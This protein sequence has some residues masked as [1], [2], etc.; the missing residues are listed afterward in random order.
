MS[1]DIDEFGQEH[2]DDLFRVARD[3]AAYGGLS[4]DQKNALSAIRTW[5]NHGTG[6]KQT[7]TLAGYA[8]TGKSYCLSVLARELQGP[9][10][11]CA[12]TG[13]ASSVLA[14]KLS[15]AG[16]ATTSRAVKKDEEGMAAHEPRP[17][18]G[19]IHGL[20][21][22][23]CPVCMIAFEDDKADE[24][25]R[26]AGCMAARQEYP[27]VEIT[28]AACVA[29]PPPPPKA[30]GSCTTCNNYRFLRRDKLDRAY[31]L[32]VCDE[33]SMVSDDLLESLLRHGVPLLAVGD[34][35]QLPPV[36]GAGSLMRY[37]DVRLEKIHRQAKGNPIIR[38]SEQIRHTGDIADELEDGKHFVIEPMRRLGDWIKKRYTPKKLGTQ[39]IMDTV[40]ISW[41][42]RLR[43]SLNRDVRDALNKTDEI[44]GLGEIVVCLKNNP[45]VYNGM[46][47]ILTTEGRETGSS[48]T[49]KIAADLW[50][51][52]D[53][54]RMPGVAMSALQF[55]EEKTI[56]YEHVKE[57]GVSFTS[58]GSL[59]DF[60]YALTCHKMQGSQAEDVGVV[61]EPG[62][63]KMGLEDRRKWIYTAV[64][65]SANKLT[66]FR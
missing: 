30:S 3:A 11:F 16:I 20:V 45:P 44:P 12:F 17:Y 34:H 46:R 39:E 5:I 7:F 61:L 63:M 35:G 24:H 8:G 21:Y 14:R 62:L 31:S 59:Y 36:R 42:N 27:A 54:I 48:R 4:V 9:V 2:T 60:G 53:D 50:F 10:A 37:P 1:G 6:T 56:D 58:L 65:R 51:A 26:T 13:K 25:T 57:M 32:I 38:L 28:C 19:T 55:F 23:P 22:R 15:Q 64:T 41:T 40:L 52:E 49:P 47:G 66:V 33:A 43:C 29:P 18:C